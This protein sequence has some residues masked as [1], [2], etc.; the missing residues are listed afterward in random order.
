M[1]EFATAVLVAASLAASCRSAQDD[2]VPAS[3]DAGLDSS[4]DSSS[5]VQ[6]DALSDPMEGSIACG[7]VEAAWQAFVGTHNTCSVDGDC[8]LVGGS[9]NYCNCAI[10]IGELGGDPI[11]VTAL[12]EAQVYLETFSACRDA[13]FQYSCGWDHGPSTNLRCEAGICKVDTQSCTGNP[14]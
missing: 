6:L 14:G 12:S 4:E 11:S 8:I 5:D 2:A 7:K 9:K 1:L 10:A 13:G 3:G